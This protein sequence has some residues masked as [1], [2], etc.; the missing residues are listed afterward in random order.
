[1]TTPLL[2][3]FPINAALLA[4]QETRR[5]TLGSIDYVVENRDNRIYVSDLELSADLKA[6]LTGPTIVTAFFTLGQSRTEID[7]ALLQGERNAF[8]LRHSGELGELQE[9]RL[10]PEGEDGWAV[11]LVP[12]HRLDAEAS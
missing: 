8:E 2:N 7:G 1:M 9:L 3:L 5:P 10:S 4:S 6:K 11:V 12:R